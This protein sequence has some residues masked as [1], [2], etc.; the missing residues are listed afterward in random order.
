MHYIFLK[1]FVIQLFRLVSPTL[2]LHFVNCLIADWSS[3]SETEG[4]GFDSTLFESKTIDIVFTTGG[5]DISY[6]FL[7]NVYNVHAIGK[8]NNIETEIYFKEQFV[9][10]PRY[11]KIVDGK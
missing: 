8:L 11:N 2:R 4:V 1:E 3:Y 7:Y 6:W 9:N 5:V 10:A